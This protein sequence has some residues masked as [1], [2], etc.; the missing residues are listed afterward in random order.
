MEEAGARH[1]LPWR[2]FGSCRRDAMEIALLSLAVIQ[3]FVTVIDV[4]VRLLR[5]R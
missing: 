2:S 1:G 4:S 5:R 3:L